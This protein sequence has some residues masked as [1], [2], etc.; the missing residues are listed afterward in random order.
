MAETNDLD[1]AVSTVCSKFKISG[2]NAFQMKAISE[3]VKGKS[4]ILVNLPT[5]YGKSLVYQALPSV[6][7][8]LTTSSGHVVVVV[9]PLV[10][11]MRDQVQSLRSIGVSSVSLSDLEE[12]EAEKG[13]KSGKSSVFGCVWHSRVL[14]KKRTLEGG[15]VKSRL[16]GKVMLRCSRRNP[17]YKSMVSF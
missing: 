6:F 17:C 2:L 15:F 12:R 13:G 9:S 11:L 16:R 10:N 5:G 8:S 1:R 3:F 7:D 14:V 4:V